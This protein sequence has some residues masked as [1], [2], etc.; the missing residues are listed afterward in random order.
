MDRVFATCN[1]VSMINDMKAMGVKC[2]MNPWNIERHRSPIPIRAAR[3]Q[4]KTHGA[5]QQG[6][7]R[8][9]RHGT[10]KKISEKWFSLDV[11]ISD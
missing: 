4:R 7:G 6:F 8:Y 5:R 9:G 10:I 2:M 11:T 3:I 1:S